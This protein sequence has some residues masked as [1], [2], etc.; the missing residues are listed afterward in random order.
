MK[1]L[2][3]NDLSLYVVPDDTPVVLGDTVIEIGSPL[4]FIIGDCSVIDTVLHVNVTPPEDWVGGKYLYKNGAW[5]LNP[6]WE[7][8][9]IA[10]GTD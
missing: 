6:A 9:Y 8:P 3:K 4:F 1:T 5:E 2:T 10:H 7:D